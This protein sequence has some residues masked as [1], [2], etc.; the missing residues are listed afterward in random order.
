MREVLQY[1]KHWQQR[2]EKAIAKA[3]ALIH[4]AKLQAQQDV[5]EIEKNAQKTVQ[6]TIE[7]A[8]KR[9]NKTLKA[10]DTRRDEILG[11]KLDDEQVAQIIA[12]M[13]ETL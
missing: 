3:E 8:R 6:D 11:Q 1:E 12:Q 13:K 2:R 7:Q 5:K 4:D 10:S 9:A